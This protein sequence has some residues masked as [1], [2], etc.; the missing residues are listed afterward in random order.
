MWSAA[1]GITYPNKPTSKGFLMFVEYYIWLY[2]ILFAFHFM[3]IIE[4]K[5]H[6]CTM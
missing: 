3:K 2:V 1:A 6:V 4:L 5:Q